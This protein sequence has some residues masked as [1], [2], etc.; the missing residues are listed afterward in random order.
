MEQ[1]QNLIKPR[2]PRGFRDYSPGELKLRDKLIREVTRVYELFGFAP[3]ETSVFEYADSL[4]KFLPESDKPDGGI[5]S[6]KDDDG[7]WIAT[8]YDLTAPLSR[9]YAKNFQTLP[10]PFRRYQLGPVFRQEQTGVGR[11]RQ[12]YQL[13]F[14]TVG[15][16]NILTDLETVK[17]LNAAFLG[18]GLKQEDFTVKVNNRKILSGFLSGLDI[19]Q[20][21]ETFTSVMRNM[22]KL[23]KLGLGEIA[24]LLGPGRKDES[25][26]FT[27][28][29]G[30]KQNQTEAI[31][32][33][34]SARSD[35]RSETLKNLKEM[36]GGNAAAEE[37][38]NELEQIGAFLGETHPNVV[39]DP[40][41]VRG[42]EYYTGP[43][44]EVELNFEVP[45]EKGQKRKFGSIAGGGRYDDLVKRFT[46]QEIP[47]VG[48]SIGLDRLMSAMVMLD[49]YKEELAFAGPVVIIRMDPN[50][51]AEYL[52]I[53]TELRAA[54]IPCEIYQ[55]SSG[56]GAQT[57]YADRRNSPA[58]I[59]LGENELRENQVS[60]KD[61]NLGRRMSGDIGDRKTWLEQK[62]AQVTVERGKLLETVRQIVS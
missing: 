49:E 9:F 11:F 33:F 16:S 34:L 54:G 45:D 27:P 6:L 40:S 37:G 36:S 55:G 62:P 59:L 56:L 4:G 20:P 5:F 31:I 10:K 28:G 2:L 47:A 30:L 21:S 18:L 52:A 39:F 41:L 29:S 26:V 60:V 7:E 8:R 25:G 13:D 22:D 38:L 23:D 50:L 43:V 1:P 35:N 15:S 24:K 32:R 51:T 17:I 14:D 61:M 12:F 53:E 3:L 58:V 48:A 44:F 57:K 19:A 46:G 42:L